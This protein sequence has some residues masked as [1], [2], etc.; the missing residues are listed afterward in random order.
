MLYNSTSP[1]GI[2]IIGI[3][4]MISGLLFCFIGEFIV[5]ILLLIWGGFFFITMMFL[6]K[7]YIP[8]KGIQKWFSP[9]RYGIEEKD[10]KTP[11]KGNSSQDDNL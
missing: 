8:N 7:Y 10:K 11:E 6:K 5:G 1:L 9:C 2:I 4:M 3:S